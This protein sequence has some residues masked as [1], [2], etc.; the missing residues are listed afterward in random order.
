MIRGEKRE[1][2]AYR[3]TRKLKLNSN[4]QMSLNYCLAWQSP[5]PPEFAFLLF[6]VDES[7]CE[8]FKLIPIEMFCLR[9]SRGG[10]RRSAVSRV[11]YA[12]W[13]IESFYFGGLQALCTEKRS[14]WTSNFPLQF[15]TPKRFSKITSRDK[16]HSKHEIEKVFQWKSL[17]LWT[18]RKT[19]A[20]ILNLLPNNVFMNLWK[21]EV[22]FIRIF[23]NSE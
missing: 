20:I 14:L 17:R 15:L 23:D 2:E 19:K 7:S 6:D 12:A 3:Q 13:K 1:L 4:I 5:P 10:S 8:T 9:Y 22:V 16:N 21:V 18:G 11:I